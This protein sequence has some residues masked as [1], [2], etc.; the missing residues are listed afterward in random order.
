MVG[1]LHKKLL[2]DLRDLKGPIL[3]IAVVV[4]CGVSAFIS[5]AGTHRVLVQARASYYTQSRM[6]DVFASVERAPE[7]LSPRLAALP[8]VSRVQ[9]RVRTGIRVPMPGLSSAADGVAI[10]IPRQGP[11][12]LGE[13]MLTAGRRPRAGHHDEVL[14]LDA[15]AKA[16]SLA[17]GATLRVVLEGQERVLRAVGFATS[18]EWVM[19]LVPGS[20]A[21]DDRRFAVVWMPRD[22]LASAAGMEGAFNDLVIE[23][24]AHASV[25]ALI[26]HWT[27]CSSPTAR[28]GL[29]ASTANPRTTSSPKSFSSSRGW[30]TSRPSSSSPSRRSC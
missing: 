13:L 17:P 1:P 20:M 11:A 22:A 4:G 19:T 16:H 23:T 12:R 30:P 24:Q 28:R 25:P 27:A 9:T 3:T 7:S 2:R 6:G 26:A 5:L 14:L 10:S 18:A 15:F 8:G 21:P 29:M